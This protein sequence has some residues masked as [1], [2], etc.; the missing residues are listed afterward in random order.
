MVVS[1]KSG[2]FEYF[3]KYLCGRLIPEDSASTYTIG[4]SGVRQFHLGSDKNGK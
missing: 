1:R 2:C 3:G 4:Y